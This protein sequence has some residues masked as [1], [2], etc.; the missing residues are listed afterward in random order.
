M[1][2]SQSHFSCGAFS[3][4]CKLVVTGLGVLTIIGWLADIEVL[5]SLRANYIPMAPST[6]LAF[7]ALGVAVLLPRKR[8]AAAALADTLIYLVTGLALAK[9]LEFVMDTSFGIDEFFISTPGEFGLVS[10]GRMSPITAGSFLLACA[11]IFSR[12]TAHF[13]NWTGGLAT[14]LLGISSVLLLGYLHKTPLLYGA[15]IIPV[16]LPTAT[17]FFLLA[18]SIIVDA[19]TERWPFRAFVGNSAKAVLL[20]WF[21]P[22]VLAVATATDLLRGRALQAWLPNP[23]VVS[24]ISTLVFVIAITAIISQVARVVG[25][26]IDKAEDERNLAQKTLE[27][28]NEN[29]E[30]TVADRTQELRLKNEQM[31]EELLMARELQFAM[32][33][34]RFPS[35][36]ENA[37]SEESLL[38]FFTFYLPT[39]QVSGDFFNVFP[40]SDTSVGVLICDVMGHG[41]RAALVAGMMRAITEQHSDADCDPGKLLARLNDSLYSILSHSGTT[42]FATGLVIIVDAGRGCFSYASAGHP[43]PLHYQRALGRPNRSMER[44][45][46]PSVSSRKPVTR[47]RLEPSSPA[48]C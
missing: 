39:S 25:G 38:G 43:K 42:M 21:L 45:A 37:G 11:A 46:R 33:P 20:R 7:G 29:L 13:G 9:L 18:C 1:A 28:L 16:A 14:V 40:V 32:L 27:T 22:V 41:V 30:K 19:G 3:T 2:P 47:P 34:K 48:I 44:P 26:R 4:V 17:A 10:K 5:A 31:E 12:R 6:A 15:T 36:P 23:A 24:A 35:V 8:R